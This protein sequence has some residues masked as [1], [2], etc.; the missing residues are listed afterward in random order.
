MVSHQW[1]LLHQRF[2]NSAFDSKRHSVSLPGLAY[3]DEQDDV[4]SSCYWHGHADA[5]H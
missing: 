5:V 2:D 3:Q 1:E 4:G